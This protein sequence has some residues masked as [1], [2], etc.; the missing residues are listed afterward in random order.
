V[1]RFERWLEVKRIF[2]AA[3][4]VEAEERAAFLDRTCGEDQE[5]RAEVEA[6]LGAPAVP[7]AALAGLLGL[8]KRQEDP[9]YAEGERIDHFA[10]VRRV[11]HG[12]MGVVYEARDTRNNDRRVALKV[13]FSRAITLSQDK[14]LAGLTHPAIVTFHD[15]GETSEGLPYF[16]FEFIEGEPVTAFCD[17]RQLAL[18]ERLRLF[19]KV[20]DPVAYAHQRGVIH[21][22]LKPENI[23]VTATGDLKLLDF[24]IAREVGAAGSAKGESSAITLPFASPEQVGNEETTTLSDVYSLGVLLAVL[25]TGRLPYRRAQ[26]VS[27]LRD[28]ILHQPPSLPSETVTA[29]G[30]GAPRIASA[31]PAENATKL[32]RQL[33]GDLDAIVAK[34]LRKEP[35]E[36]YQSAPDLAADI[37]RDLRDLPVL[38]RGDSRLYRLSK[39]LK[40]RRAT[41]VAAALFILLALGGLGL[42]WRQYRETVRQRDSAELEAAHDKELS[43]FLF[44][45]F[46]IYN[47]DRQPGDAVTVREL[48]DQAHAELGAHLKKQPHLQARLLNTLGDLYQELSLYKDTERCLEES[49]AIERREHAAEGL[50]AAETLTRF[51]TLR[52]LQGRHAEAEQLLRHSLRIEEAALPAN[53]PKLTYTLFQLASAVNYQGR[54][55]DAEALD[56]RALALRRKAPHLDPAAIAESLNSLGTNLSEMSR[57]REALPL[58]QESLAIRESLY[59]SGHPLIL[60]AKTHLANVMLHEG[61]YDAAIRLQEEVLTARR[62]AYGAKSHDGAVDLVNLGVYEMVKGDYPR[63]EATLRDGLREVAAVLG[64]DHPQTAIAEMQLARA[65]AGEKKFADARAA[66]RHAY[67]QCVKSVGPNHFLAGAVLQAEAQV[68][69]RAGDY[70]AAENLYRRAIAIFEKSQGYDSY[71]RVSTSAQLGSTLAHL[72]QFA[73]AEPLLLEFYARAIPEEK[74]NAANRLVDLYD[75]WGKTDKAG[76]FRNLLKRLPPS[77][78]TFSPR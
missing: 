18:H 25:V 50:I 30:D 36:R 63:A 9:D 27:E 19:Q 32:A 48:L 35:G 40:R 45:I 75:A 33:R 16:V 29:A 12:G 4:E 52:R 74:A 57:F 69:F 73:P 64:T 70:A 58:L 51:G 72:R 42:W 10:I 44:R 38:A 28:A 15:S 59:S 24:G 53:D 61:Q 68:E 14:R 67:D 47:P 13:L 49:L 54:H 7:T 5:L 46:L 23:L 1:A 43:D 21:C 11:G 78:G 62:R 3:L 41:A 34:A 39:L 56:R 31:P 66:V 37:D 71:N 65:L 26:T 6:L 17:R 77:T 55:R 8:P 60:N 76:H 20:C 22:D 2:E